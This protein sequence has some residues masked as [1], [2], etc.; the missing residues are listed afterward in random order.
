MRDPL[1]KRLPRQFIND[2]GKYL[3][4]VILMAFSIALEAGYEVGNG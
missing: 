1:N 2:L 4:I 3:V